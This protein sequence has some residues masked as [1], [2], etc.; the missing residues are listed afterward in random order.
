MKQSVRKSV[1]I[2]FFKSVDMPESQSYQGVAG[3]GRDMAYTI[4]SQPR[5]DHFDTAAYEIEKTQIGTA[6]CIPQSAAHALRILLRQSIDRRAFIRIAD[7]PPE[8]KV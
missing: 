6:I 8:I 2:Q 5:Y 3:S 1:D 7:G 4:S